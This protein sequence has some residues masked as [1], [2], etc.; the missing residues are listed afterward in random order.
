MG[1]NEEIMWWSNDVLSSTSSKH[2]APNLLITDERAAGFKLILV[3]FHW[4]YTDK[5]RMVI[6]SKNSKIS[7]NF[8]TI[9]N[10]SSRK[11]LVGTYPRIYIRNFSRGGQQRC[12]ERQQQQ[13]QQ[14]HPTSSTSSSSSASSSTAVKQAH[15]CALCPKSFS[16]ARSVYWNFFISFLQI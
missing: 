15:Q 10:V 4:D 1:L 7:V 13:Q 12:Q 11:P 5:R 14:N 2:S 3:T 8:Y 9:L 6:S 16:S